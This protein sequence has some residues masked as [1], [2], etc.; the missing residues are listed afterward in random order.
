MPVILL[1][2]SISET[3][4]ADDVAADIAK[5]L[6]EEKAELIGKKSRASSR[7]CGKF[8]KSL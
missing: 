2:L 5:K 7:H 1:D 8:L 6:N 3:D 4:P